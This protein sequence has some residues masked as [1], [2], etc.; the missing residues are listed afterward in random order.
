MGKSERLAALGNTL[1]EILSGVYEAD[2]RLLLIQF[3]KGF[4]I[5]SYRKQATG[6]RRAW[7]TFIAVPL[8]LDGYI[9]DV[10]VNSTTGKKLFG[11]LSVKDKYFGLSTLTGTLIRVKKAGPTAQNYELAVQ[12]CQVLSDYDSGHC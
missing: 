11:D 8:L 9:R 5:I 10:R 2:A 3:V 4:K 6:L 7:Y 12:I 1:N